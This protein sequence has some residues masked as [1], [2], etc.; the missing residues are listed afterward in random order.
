MKKK[1]LFLKTCQLITF[2]LI[3]FRLKFYSTEENSY[4]HFYLLKFNNN[5]KKKY[6]L[7]FNRNLGFLSFKIS[8]L[9]R[10]FYL[11]P[12]KYFPE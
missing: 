12:L 11:R 1:G 5:I 2:N 4:F 10:I 3:L 7:K 9:Q 8:T 6:T